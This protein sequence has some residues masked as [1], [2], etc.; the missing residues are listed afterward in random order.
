VAV[1]PGIR[2]VF[3]MRGTRVIFDPDPREYWPGILPANEPGHRGQSSPEPVSIDHRG[4]GNHRDTPGIIFYRVR[5]T[6]P[7]SVYRVTTTGH[8]FTATGA[9]AP[10]G[11]FGRVIVSVFIR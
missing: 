10:T 2:V 9:V 1:T 7:D 6:E 3:A 5:A 8:D 4:T 11:I